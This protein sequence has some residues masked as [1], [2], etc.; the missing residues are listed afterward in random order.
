MD[1]VVDDSANV[2]FCFSVYSCPYSLGSRFG[3]QSYSS[4][5][6]RSSTTACCDCVCSRFRS[7]PTPFWMSFVRGSFP[8]TTW[9]IWSSSTVP[10]PV[11]HATHATCCRRKFRSET[12]RRVFSF[13]NNKKSYSLTTIRWLD[14]GFHCVYILYHIERHHSIDLKYLFL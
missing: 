7:S 11:W 12:R 4:G 8:R 1:A 13:K 6:H 14:R 2:L 9:T 3:R 5:S 10:R